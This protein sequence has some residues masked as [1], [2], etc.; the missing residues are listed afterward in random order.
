MMTA[1]SC[2]ICWLR[3]KD[4]RFLSA[5]SD[6]SV[7]TMQ[8]VR[9]WE[10]F[11]IIVVKPMT[12]C[13]M[14]HQGTFLCVANEIACHKSLKDGDMPGP[15][16]QF[17]VSVVEDGSTTLRNVASRGLLQADTFTLQMTWQVS[18]YSGGI[19]GWRA[20]ALGRC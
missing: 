19:C 4:G 18:T 20:R 10:W 8:H 7:R 1:K 14:T 2:D 15:E 13:L 6:G 16:A 17:E 11:T 3:S 9:S 5:W 12:V